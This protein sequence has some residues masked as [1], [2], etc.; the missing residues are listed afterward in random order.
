M[1]ARFRTT[2]EVGKLEVREFLEKVY[3]LPVVS[4][5]TVIIQGKK[6]KKALGM[7]KRILTQ[8]PDYK[9]VWVQFAPGRI[10][11]VT[12]KKKKPPVKKEVKTPAQVLQ[13]KSVDGVTSIQT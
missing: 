12:A 10:Y 3:N 1:Q 8:T 4:V 2:P 6:K 7:N 13:D 9:K 5:D 11:P